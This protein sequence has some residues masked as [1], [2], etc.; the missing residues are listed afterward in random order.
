MY[1]ICDRYIPTFSLEHEELSLGISGVK[2][3]FHAHS[4]LWACYRP[5][6]TASQPKKDRKF[7]GY[8]A[9]KF[10]IGI[11]SHINIHNVV[12]KKHVQNQ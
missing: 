10:G 5:W 2:H 8:Y 3:I 6:V 11:V 12:Y 1:T 9:L 7:A 4:L